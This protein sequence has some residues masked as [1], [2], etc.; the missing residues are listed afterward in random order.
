MKVRQGDLL[1][2]R[3][4][5]LPENSVLQSHRVLAEGEA[6]GHMHELDSGELY[7]RE[8]TLFFKVLE[9]QKTTLNHQEHGPITFVPGVYKVIRQR[10]YEPRGWRRVAD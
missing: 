2:V 10:E 3:V 5:G 1:I 9:G 7:E 8:G 6:T 4:D